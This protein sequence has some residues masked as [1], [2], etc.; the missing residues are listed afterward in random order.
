MSKKGYGAILRGWLPWLCA[1]ALAMTALDADAAWQDPVV[2][3]RAVVTCAHQAASEAGRKMLAEGGGAVDAAVAMS[4]ALSVVEPWG[5]GLGGGAF[6]V[7]HVAGQTTSLDMREAAPAAAHAD[8]FV[9][10]GKVIPGET[11]ASARAAA[12]PGLVRGLAVLHARF[13]RLP[14][15]QVV[16][17]AI[18]LARDGV[19]VTPRM[20]AAISDALP[21][22]N[23]AARA[24]FAPSGVAPAVGSRLV[25]PE[26]A[27]TLVRI[28]RTNGEDFYAGETARRMVAAVSAEGGL[29]TERDLTGYAVRERPVVRG[30]WRGLEVVSMGPPSSGGLL[31]LQML[32]VLERLPE[33]DVPPGAAQWRGAERLHRLAETMKRAFA[34]RALGLGDP[35]FVPVDHARFLAPEVLDAL[36]SDVRR[37]RRATPATRLSPLE[38]RAADRP[39]T[40]H[41]AVLTSDGEAVALTQTINLRFGTGRVAQGTGVV[42]NNEMDDFSAQPGV[43]NAFGLVG[44][45]GNAIAPGKR[46][47]SSMTPT[48]VLRE[49]RAVGVFGSPGGSRIIT[50]TL[51]NML[52]VVVDGLDPAEALGAERVHHQWYPDELMV[53]A[54]ALAP[55]TAVALT[56]LGHKLRVVQPMGNAMILWRQG[57][58]RLEG[59]ADPRGEG[60][61]L[62]L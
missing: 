61:A 5:S 26:L 12:I 6:A 31:L 38:V 11:T 19:V 60:A 20:R 53:E 17:P 47:L 34:M 48:I 30:A 52:R 7:V 51:Q 21:G 54:T 9:R 39:D 10:E 37:A 49:G 46:P 14:F 33:S 59:A 44:D 15:E 22:M 23:Q 55:E 56:R 13:G 58:G 27:E 24:V 28:A 18:G 42:L 4:L 45:A 1:S 40:S 36:A 16:A 43:P 2:G 29:W 32:G 3:E 50:T 57:E 62:G 25:Q 35:D 41:L 8:M